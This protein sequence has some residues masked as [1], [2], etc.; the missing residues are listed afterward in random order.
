MEDAQRTSPVLGAAEEVTGMA[1]VVPAGPSTA[2]IPIKDG[3]EAM[4]PLA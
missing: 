4:T 1:L 2:T 3:P